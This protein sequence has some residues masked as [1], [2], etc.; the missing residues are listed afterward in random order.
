[1]NAYL[2]EEDYPFSPTHN[3]SV[4]L[5]S[6]SPPTAIILAKEDELLDPAQMYLLRENFGKLGVECRIYEA[7]GM[8]HGIIE[9]PTTTWPEGNDWWNDILAPALDW[10]SER[11]NSV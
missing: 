6:A 9:S 2:V 10:V 5:T 4:L 3:P 8:K 11:T 7:E 1:L